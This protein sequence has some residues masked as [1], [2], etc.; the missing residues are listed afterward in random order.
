MKL[1]GEIRLFGTQT[2]ANDFNG[3]AQIKVYDKLKNLQT[4]GSVGGKF[5]Y[6]QYQNLLFEGQVKVQNGSFNGT[7]VVPKDINYQ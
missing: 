3:V 2:K 6:Q 4:L 1:E 5:A 7:F